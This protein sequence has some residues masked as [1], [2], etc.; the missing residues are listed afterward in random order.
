MPEV[1]ILSGFLGAGKTT[2]LKKI[3]EQELASNRK[4]AVIMNELGRLSI[5]SMAI[6]DDIP[7]KELLNGCICCSIS[8]QLEVHLQELL[9]FDHF[10]AIFIE[11]TG[12]A[13]PLEVLDVC[14]SPRFAEKISLPSIVT[15]LDADR[16]EQKERLSLRH[17]KLLSEQVKHADTVIINK[18]DL[19]TA[20]SLLNI[21]NEVKALNPNGKMIESTF[22]DVS[23][24]AFQLKV[25]LQSSK[26][27]K[28]EPLHA[29]DHLHLKS[30]VHT[31]ENP[32]EKEGFAAFLANMPNSILRIKGYL[33]FKESPNQT[34]MVQYAYGV[35]LF[36][37][38]PVHFKNNLVFIGEN[39]DRSWLEKELMKLEENKL[40]TF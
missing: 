22:S 27:N 38:E 8:G 32:V 16:W 12:A 26:R 18:I 13:H 15:L 7:L 17:R 24:D 11:T 23:L 14:L 39:L 3:L 19:V 35:P 9:E 29:F 21:C 6:Q 34:M 25:K 40:K 31:F 30:Y 5:D 1:Y 4:V 20:E 2:L 10:D 28:L 36:T 37:Y 33:R